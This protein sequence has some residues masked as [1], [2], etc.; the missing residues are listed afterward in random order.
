[1]KKDNNDIKELKK[2]LYE[3]K[4]TTEFEEK[5]PHQKVGIIAKNVYKDLCDAEKRLQM[6][7]NF[8][9]DGQVTQ[10]DL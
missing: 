4:N 10:N 3:Y 2:S 6:A 1:M 5:K 9:N 7:I 8:K